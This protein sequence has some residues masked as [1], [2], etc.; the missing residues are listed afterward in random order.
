MPIDAI[1]LD[2]W[3]TTWRVPNLVLFP[4]GFVILAWATAAGFLA[5]TGSQ[6]SGQPEIHFPK[7][8]PIIVDEPEDETPEQ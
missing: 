8:P 7:E 4:I 3:E 5:F 6:A 1:V 2:I